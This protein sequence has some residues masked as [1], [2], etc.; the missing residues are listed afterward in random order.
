MWAKS[1]Q[2]CLTV[3][4]Q[5]PLSMGFSRQEYYSGLLWPP[6]GDLPNPEIEPTSLMPPALAGV[7]FTTG[8]TWWALLGLYTKQIQV[9]GGIWSTSWSLPMPNLSVSGNYQKKQVSKFPFPPVFFSLHSSFH[10]YKVQ[11][12]SCDIRTVPLSF[13]LGS[14]SVTKLSLTLAAPWTVACQVPLSMGFSR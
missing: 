14:G 9:E 12:L 4:H 7:L 3:A 10:P 1:L 5:A 8:T 13:Y 11:I 6:L 2:S